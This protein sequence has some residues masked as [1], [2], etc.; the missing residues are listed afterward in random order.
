M[1]SYLYKPEHPGA[2]VNGFID[3]N[4]YYLYESL[5]KPDNRMLVGNKVVE[6]RFNS[7]TMPETRHMCNGK[8][9][10]SKKKFRDE[11]RAH[12]CIEVGNETK[13]LTK[14][15]KPIELSRKGRREDIKK[16]MYEL[17]NR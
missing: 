6:V 4:D 3:K 17:R 2:N 9:Y 10:T 12:G 16:A 14:P 8:Y 1:A 11:T 15:R 5:N 13:T 7:D